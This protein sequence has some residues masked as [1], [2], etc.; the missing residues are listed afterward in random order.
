MN[1][2]TALPPIPVRGDSGPQV[3]AV[4]Q[5]YLALLNDL[6]PEQVQA[7]SRHLDTCEQCT[8]ERQ[9]IQR[10]TRLLASLPPSEPS[11]RVDQ[12]ILAALADHQEEQVQPQ[13]SLSTSPRRVK[14]RAPLRFIGQ[15]AAAAV[16]VL[17]ILSGIHLFG[18]LSPG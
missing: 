9:R 7:V 1:E 16:L 15:L 5:L 17:A 18:L 2:D 6:S 12:A 11:P 13:M 10:A 3:C 14:R 8:R 4:I